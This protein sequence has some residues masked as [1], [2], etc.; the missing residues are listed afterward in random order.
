[1]FSTLS[2]NDFLLLGCLIWR[3]SFDIG[4]VTAPRQSERDK[5]KPSPM[6]KR[7]RAFRDFT[8]YQSRMGLPDQERIIE[9]RARFVYGAK[10]YPCLTPKRT[11]PD[12]DNLMKALL[13]S[14]YPEGDQCIPAIRAEKFYGKKDKVEVAIIYKATE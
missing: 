14:L 13:D 3:R 5:F 10:N 1:M 12:V 4:P 9:V 8:Y 2:E 7:Y 6:V 11:A